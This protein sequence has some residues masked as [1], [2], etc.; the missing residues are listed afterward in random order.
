VIALVKIGSIIAAK[1]QESGLTQTQ[2]ATLVGVNQIQISR[3]ENDKH[4]PT[5]EQFVNIAA[6][7]HCS[8]DE[9]AGL[10]GAKPEAQ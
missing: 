6:A 1:R 10:S 2:L 9:L 7:L 3:W 8:L 5:I 4:L